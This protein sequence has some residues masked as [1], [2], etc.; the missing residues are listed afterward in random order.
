MSMNDYSISETA[1]HLRAVLKCYRLAL[2]VRPNDPPGGFHVTD[3][4]LPLRQK[5]AGQHQSLG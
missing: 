5:S 1:P 4:S 2:S 3:V